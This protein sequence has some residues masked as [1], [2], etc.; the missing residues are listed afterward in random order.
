MAFLNASAIAGM[1]PAVAMAVFAMM[2]AAPI[3]I[4]SHACDGRPMPASTMIGRSISSMR[5]LMKS[6]VARPL[7][8]PIGAAS[9]MMQAAPAFTRSRAAYRSGYIYGMTTK[10][11][12]ARISVARMVS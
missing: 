1:S 10:P 8:V 9:G 3:S 5:I 11:S 7:F 12:F 6:R 4:A 2:A